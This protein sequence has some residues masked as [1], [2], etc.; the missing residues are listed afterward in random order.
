MAAE[1]GALPRRVGINIQHPAVVMPHQA[2][3][4]VEHHVRHARGFDPRV[5]LVPANRVI[6]QH[7]GDL[8]ENQSRAV[9]NVGDFR[10]RARAAMRQPFAGHGGAVAHFIEIRVVNRRR[11]REDSK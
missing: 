4:V 9:E 5:H 2:E 3:A 8:M 7:P 10:H 1:R 6:M 11:R